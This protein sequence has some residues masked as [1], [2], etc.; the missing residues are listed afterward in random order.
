MGGRHEWSGL[1]LRQGP[2][3]GQAAAGKLHQSVI[4]EPTG[5]WDYMPNCTANLVHPKMTRQHQLVSMTQYQRQAL[6]QAS[7]M[8]NHS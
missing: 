6:F 5:R 8:I 7:D 1:R 2:Q 3:T 4:N